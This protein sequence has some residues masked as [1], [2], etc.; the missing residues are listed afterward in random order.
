MKR[1]KNY[2]LQRQN[3]I[4]ILLSLGVL[5]LIVRDVPF[6]NI[7]FPQNSILAAMFIIITILFKWYKN[8]LF[9]L[10]LVIPTIILF[11]TR[12]SQAEQLAILIFFILALVIVDETISL[13]KDESNK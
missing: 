11:I 7:F 10:I 3:I 13:I 9:F 12:S 6:L 4:L 1:I 5:L 2:F 8:Y